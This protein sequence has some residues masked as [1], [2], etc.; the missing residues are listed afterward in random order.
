MERSTRET[1]SD[2]QLVV[3]RYWWQEDAPPLAWAVPRQMLVA[4][5]AGALIVTILALLFFVWHLQVLTSILFI[6]HSLL[7]ISLLPRWRR[8]NGLYEVDATG[9]PRAFVSH[10]LLPGLTFRNSMSRKRFLQ[11]V[12]EQAAGLLY[13]EQRPATFR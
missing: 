2:R 10:A 4:P 9:R 13:Q 5:L 6:L 3:C 8:Y 12:S 7:G 11:R 1:L